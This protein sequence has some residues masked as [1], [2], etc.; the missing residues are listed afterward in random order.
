MEE[1]RHEASNWRRE[2]KYE[3]GECKYVTVCSICGRI[4]CCC[5]KRWYQYFLLYFVY[6]AL[7]IILTVC[8]VQGASFALRGVDPIILEEIFEF[9]TPVLIYCIF[10]TFKVFDPNVWHSKLCGLP[11]MD[12]TKAYEGLVSVEPIKRKPANTDDMTCGCKH[13]PAWR[14]A[15]IRVS[16]KRIPRRCFICKECGTLIE[17]QYDPMFFFPGFLSFCLI[18]ALS[19]VVNSSLAEHIT[20]ENH[21]TIEMLMIIVRLACLALFIE[22]REL[23]Y[24]FNR[25]TVWNVS[26][27]NEKPHKTLSRWVSC[28]EEPCCDN[29]SES[30]GGD[31]PLQKENSPTE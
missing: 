23:Y 4:I 31:L 25:K 20:P 17:P 8:I 22:I 19:V 3:N 30:S 5:K 26:A 16:G 6:F 9:V 28:K 24:R 29:P 14:R 21:R 12:D 15:R 2:A 18:V 27:Y 11:F 7:L 10:F 1:C 13:K